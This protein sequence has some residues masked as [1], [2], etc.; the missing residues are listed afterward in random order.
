LCGA[1]YKR[2]VPTYYYCDCAF[3]YPITS[4]EKL[5]TKITLEEGSQ[6]I[7][8]FLNGVSLW[9]NTLMAME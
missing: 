9:K 7:E 2:G 5:S 8:V 6:D 3:S 4:D 1:I